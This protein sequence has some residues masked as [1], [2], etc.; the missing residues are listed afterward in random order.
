MKIFSIIFF[1]LFS[2]ISFHLGMAATQNLAKHSSEPMFV[3]R[4]ET[5]KFVAGEII[6]LPC[7]VSNAGNLIPLNYV[8]YHNFIQSTQIRIL[9][10]HK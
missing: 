4:S 5:F 8:L 2:F 10:I 6:H 9:H 1:F 3:T 7:E